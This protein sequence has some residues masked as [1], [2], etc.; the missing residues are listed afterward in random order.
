MSK[1]RIFMLNHD[2]SASRA[3]IIRLFTLIFALFS[4]VLFMPFIVSGKTFVYDFDG[5]KQHLIAYTYYGRLVREIFHTVFVNHKFVLPQFDLTIGYGSDIIQTLNYYCIGDPF[6]FFSFLVPESKTYAFYTAMNIVRLYCAGLSFIYLCAEFNQTKPIAVISGTFIYVFYLYA[7]INA[8]K[9]PY[10]LNPLVFFPLIIVGIERIIQSKSPKLF[11]FATSI[12]AA[13]NLYFFYMM[14]VLAA[15]F[16]IVRL[17]DLNG[18]NARSILK[19]IGSLMLF[20]LL[21]VLISSVFFIPAAY[22][23]LVDPRMGEFNFTLLYPRSHY[24]KII[25]NLFSIREDFWMTFSFPLVVV[26]SWLSFFSKPNKQKSKTMTVL[27]VMCVIFLLFPIF[28]QIL[29]GFSYATNRWNW[30]FTLLVAFMLVSEWENIVSKT[31]SKKLR[32]M[33]LFAL[34]CLLTLFL[35]HRVTKIRK[36]L[37]TSFFDCFLIQLA[38][39]VAFVFAQPKMSK[40][41]CEKAF[42]VFICSFSVISGFFY[43]TKIGDNYIRKCLSSNEIKTIFAN[44]SSEIKTLTSDEKTFFRYV[45]NEIDPF[46]SDEN[47]SMISRIPSTGFYW[48]LMNSSIGEYHDFLAL[49]IKQAFRYKNLDARAILTSLASVKYCLKNTNY[50]LPFGFEPTEHERIFRNTTSLPLGYTYDTFFLRSNVNALSPSQKEEV[51]LSSLIVDEQ[52]ALTVEN[53]SM[54]FE[55]III[56]PELQANGGGD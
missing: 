54:Q 39:F 20:A 13:S 52:L 46:L 6:A 15:I 56:S 12:S 18:K 24:L 42:L 37:T 17:I 44:E 43:Y 29:N 32:F 26:L 28:G 22:A 48:T 30:A 21:S 38:L 45:T 35:F 4:V 36:L 55:S 1:S 41:S 9:H 47:I 40:K 49:P 51:M 50:P 23:F 10:F 16:A 53:H 31:L 25:F 3:D 8:V 14:T 33:L 19:K 7:I 34:A 5:I 27:F 2:E 11:V